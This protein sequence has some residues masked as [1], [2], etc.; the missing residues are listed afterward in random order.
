M[1]PTYLFPLLCFFL[2][3]GCSRSERASVEAPPNYQAPSE[4]AIARLPKLPAKESEV[5]ETVKRIFKGSAVVREPISSSFAAGDF[6]GDVVEDI[7]I[8]VRSAPSKVSELNN[9]YPPWILSDLAATTGNTRPRIKE[10]D[11][12]LAIVH[13]YGVNE[14]RDSEATQTFLLRNAVGNDLRTHELKKFLAAN[15]GR[16]LPQLQGDLVGQVLNGSAGFLYYS[17]AT[18]SWYDPKNFL[19]EPRKRLVHMGP[20]QVA[21]R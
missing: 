18:Y 12:L 4:P 16:R 9:E 10:S 11:L 15:T 14:W 5:R 21:R 19:D 13:G 3:V 7:A 6:N 17:G 2:L 8:V 1:K 20:R